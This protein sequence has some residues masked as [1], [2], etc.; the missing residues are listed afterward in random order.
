MSFETE[1]K[2]EGEEE[3]SDTLYDSDNIDSQLN[4]GSN[5]GRQIDSESLEF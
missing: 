4:G 1:G 3:E 2:E 5:N